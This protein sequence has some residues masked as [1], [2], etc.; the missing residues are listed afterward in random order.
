MIYICER[1]KW[2]KH[3]SI[4]YNSIFKEKKLIGRR[5]S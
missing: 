5:R 1:R 2:K 3:M 4:K